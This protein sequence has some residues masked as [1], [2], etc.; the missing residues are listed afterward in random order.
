MLGVHFHTLASQCLLTKARLF[1]PG[2]TRCNEKPGEAATV[3][4]G[5]ESEVSR[6]GGQSR[7]V[8]SAKLGVRVGVR[9]VHQRVRAA[10]QY[11]HHAGRAAGAP[12]EFRRRHDLGALAGQR[13]ELGGRAERGLLSQRPTALLVAQQLFSEFSFGRLSAG[14]AGA[15]FDVGVDGAPERR[16]RG[17]RPPGG[18]RP[19]AAAAAAAA[20]GGRGPQRAPPLR[21]R[22]GV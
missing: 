18:A 8:L 5:D 10:H 17:P 9:P 14:V 13:A 15:A 21:E 16:R 4:V 1:F 12:R 6:A 7:G 3:E 20:Q 2:H 22:T 19:P 11:E